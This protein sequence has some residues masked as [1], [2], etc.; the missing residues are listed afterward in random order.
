MIPGIKRPGM[1]YHRPAWYIYIYLKA[2]RVE[3]IRF[4]R[5]ATRGKRFEVVEIKYSKNNCRTDI[6]YFTGASKLS[7]IS[8]NDRRN[9]VWQFYYYQNKLFRRCKEDK[10]ESKIDKMEKR[11]I[12]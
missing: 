4:C 9:N 3:R 12:I 8:K 11:I 1:D 7:E 2:L 5:V 6:H 10:E